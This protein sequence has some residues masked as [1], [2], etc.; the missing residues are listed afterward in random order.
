MVSK[1]Q[2]RNK[3]KAK[4]A[5]QTINAKKTMDILTMSTKKITLDDLPTKI[6]TKKTITFADLP[7]ELVSKIVDYAVGD[8]DNGIYDDLWEAY[9]YPDVPRWLSDANNLYWEVR[10]DRLWQVSRQFQRCLWDILSHRL[11]YQEYFVPYYI[12]NGFGTCE[13]EFRMDQYHK[14]LSEI[15]VWGDKNLDITELAGEAPYVWA[16]IAP[17]DLPLVDTLPQEVWPVKYGCGDRRCNVQRCCLGRWLRAL[18]RVD[19]VGSAKRRQAAD[20]CHRQWPDRR[21]SRGRRLGY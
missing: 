9:E 21:G 20:W 16:Y 6:V 7:E 5:K 14:L 13:L 12:G 2:T 17:Q 18:E 1:K 10:V 8:L 3:K 15:P 4:D 19:D 11:R